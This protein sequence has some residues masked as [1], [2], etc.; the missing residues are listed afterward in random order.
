MQTREGTVRDLQEWLMRVR[1]SRK[2]VVTAPYG[3]AL[4]GGAE[5]VMAG[6]Q[7]VAAPDCRIGLVE[8]GVG[9]IPAGGGCKELL[10]RVVSPVA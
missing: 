7:M 4:G 10:R 1:F 3:R 2:P 8:V 6:A 9:V 5:V